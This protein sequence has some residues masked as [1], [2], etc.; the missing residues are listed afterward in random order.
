MNRRSQTSKGCGPSREQPFPNIS[1]TYILGVVVSNTT[2]RITHLL[3]GVLGQSGALIGTRT[4]QIVVLAHCGAPR[5]HHEVAVVVIV[6]GAVVVRGILP[7]LVVDRWTRAPRAFFRR[8]HHLA[9]LL[10]LPP[11][12]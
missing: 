12:L 11:V 6:V 5:L 8:F 3:L 10:P 7:G 9:H 1:H 4:G 2:I